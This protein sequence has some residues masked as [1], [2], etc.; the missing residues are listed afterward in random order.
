MGHWH[1]GLCECPPCFV[2]AYLGRGQ[3]WSRPEPTA[4]GER[5][6]SRWGRG[7]NWGRGEIRLGIGVYGLL[8]DLDVNGG[9]A[10]E[11]LLDGYEGVPW[12]YENVILSEDYRENGRVAEEV[13]ALMYVDPRKRTGTCKEEYVGRMNR[14][15]K[16]AIEIGVP[17]LWVES[18]VRRFVPAESAQLKEGRSRRSSIE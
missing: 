8:Y 14:G 2:F 13:E 7:R 15:L 17:A 9:G 11:A 4:C 10:D 16:D 5:G 12:A 6:G 18:V 3:C 1:Q